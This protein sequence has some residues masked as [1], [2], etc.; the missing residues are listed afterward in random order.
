[1][2]VKVQVIFYACT[3]HLSHVR[4]WWKGPRS[5]KAPK[6][7]CTK[8]RTNTEERWRMGAKAARAPSARSDC[9]AWQLAEPT[10]YLR[11]ANRFGN[12]CAQM[13]QLS[14]PDR[15]TLGQRA[16]VGK[17]AAFSRPRQP[18]RCQETTITS[19]HSTLLHHGMVSSAFRIANTPAE[20]GGDHRRSPYG[21]GTLAGADGKRMPTRTS[22]LSRGS[23]ASRHQIAKNGRRLKKAAIRRGKAMATTKRNPTTQDPERRSRTHRTAARDG[24]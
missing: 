12:M 6:S 21:A 13:P 24:A 7:A 17:V 16:L 10:P 19:F 5:R 14:G 18:A 15:Q 8:S 1:V 22:W 11:Y 20:Y 9:H 2:S 23:R 3:P 4:A